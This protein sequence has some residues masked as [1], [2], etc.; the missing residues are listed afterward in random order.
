MKFNLRFDSNWQRHETFIMTRKT[1]VT[2][3][4]THYK[5]AIFVFG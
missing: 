1:D 2:A 4:I 5:F 3:D